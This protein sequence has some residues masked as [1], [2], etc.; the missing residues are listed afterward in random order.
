MPN[1]DES[2]ME[3]EDDFLDES[4]LAELD[5]GLPSRMSEAMANEVRLRLS[6]S[7]KTHNPFHRYQYGTILTPILELPLLWAPPRH[8]RRSVATQRR[9]PSHQSSR[10]FLHNLDGQ[11]KLI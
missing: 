10:R 5:R 11:R 4:Q 6:F 3:L 8:R 1:S 2:D 9:P 7:L